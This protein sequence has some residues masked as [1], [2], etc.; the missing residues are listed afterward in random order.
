LARQHALYT[1]GGDDRT[2]E[3][4][5]RAVEWLKQYQRDD[6]SWDPQQ[7]GAGIER[8]VAGVH[9]EGAGGKATTGISG[10]ALLAMLG[11][12][13]THQEGAQQD[14]VRSG[15]Q[16]LLSV[17]LPSGA[18]FANADP[19]ARTYSHGM[20]TLAM[21]EAAAMTADPVAR[22]SASRGVGYTVASQHPTSG[23]W[24]YVAGDRG[25]M[26]QHGWQ[27]MVMV[28]G[29][30]AGVAIPETAF[31]R[32]RTFLRT[33]RAGKTGGLA[34]YRPGEAPSRTMTAEALATRLMLGEKIPPAELAEAQAFILEEM[35]GTGTDNYY[36][37]YYASLALHQLQNDAWRQWNERMK[38]RLLATQ[39]PDGSWSTATVWGGHGGKVYTTA[40]ACLCLEVY[41]RHLVSDARGEVATRSE[42]QFIKR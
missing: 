38:E 17:Q 31:D 25:D 14:S 8:S 10:L 12:G 36:Y 39:L 23:G 3:A 5:Q 40:M 29:R 22:D 37:W 9:R 19:Y 11:A 35:P 16:Y 41:Y 2:E 4:V 30:A 26:S 1:T 27:V 24:R 34:S 18:L 32:A 20:A 6:G 33:V 42:S 15:L 28:S 21:C 13:N 7:S